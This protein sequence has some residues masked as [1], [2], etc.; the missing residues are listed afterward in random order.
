MMR[1]K[2]GVKLWTTVMLMFSM[3]IFFGCTQEEKETISPNETKST[4]EAITGEAIVE[5]DPIPIVKS[6]LTGLKIDEEKLN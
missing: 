1:K 2:Q 3:L 5:S 4:P 6:P